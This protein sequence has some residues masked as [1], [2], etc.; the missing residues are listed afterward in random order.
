MALLVLMLSD[1]QK[2]RES[3]KVVR[4]E[5][6][7]LSRVWLRRNNRSEKHIRAE[8]ERLLFVA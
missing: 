6:V 4:N 3:L 2:T 8:G 5:Q 1:M 7:C